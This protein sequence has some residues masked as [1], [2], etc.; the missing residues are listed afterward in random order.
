[1]RKPKF[2][3]ILFSPAMVR[4]IAKGIKTQTRRVVKEPVL[5]WIK[6]FD[7][8][9]E[10]NPEWWKK[11]Y[12]ACLYGQPGDIL[13]V[14]ESHYRFGHWETDDTRP[15]K[16]GRQAWKF[17]ADTDEIRYDDN[18]PADFRK[19]RHHLDPLTPAW[20]KRNSLFMPKAASRFF[21]KIKYIRAERLQSI[22]ETDAKAEGITRIESSNGP[23]Y[24]D[25]SI[26]F[27][28]SLTTAYLSFKSLWEKING[29]ESW[30]ANPW[31]WVIEFEK[32]DKPENFK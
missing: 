10:G 25:Y 31:V 3:P 18:P 26:G 9:G 4:A 2:I 6:D 11:L 5:T 30:T 19:G 22:T 17:V 21:L 7:K 16:S 15:R 24:L 1:M 14:R 32:I 20:H 29:A 13:Y 27:V 12:T 8:P 23:C 28:N